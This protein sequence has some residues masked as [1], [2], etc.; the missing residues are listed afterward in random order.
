MWSGTSANML[1][2]LRHHG[3]LLNDNLDG[4]MSI[5]GRR[6]DVS[7]GREIPAIVVSQG[8]LVSG[9]S[10]PLPMPMPPPPVPMAGQWAFLGQPGG[11]PGQG[12]QHRPQQFP[13]RSL[14]RFRHPHS[15]S[16]PLHPVWLPQ[17]PTTQA[18][19]PSPS[20]PPT[21][22]D[23]PRPRPPQPPGR[24]PGNTNPPLFP[25]PQRPPPFPPHP[26]HLTTINSNRSLSPMSLPPTPTTPFERSP[27][28]SPPP[29]TPP[30]QPTS[31]VSPG[32]LR[33]QSTP[34]SPWRS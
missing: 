30:A 15:R 32:S 1:G 11:V 13:L 28:P 29:G 18:F 21:I 9:P 3:C 16:Q 14:R 27:A 19:Q 23:T 22:S 10:P 5:V 8:P 7:D 25:P 17:P 24:A 34:P 20:F 31:P 33:R 4:T 26:H 6:T 12:Q 2:Q